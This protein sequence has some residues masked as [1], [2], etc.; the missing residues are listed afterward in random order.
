[1]SRTGCGQEQAHVW[2][3]R[4]RVDPNAVRR[5]GVGAPIL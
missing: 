5:P 2:A 3:I 1:M 4:K